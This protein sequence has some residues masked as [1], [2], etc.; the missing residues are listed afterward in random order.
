MHRLKTN[1]LQ[2]LVHVG[3][4]LPLAVLV[5]EFT[6]DGLTV[7][8]IQEIQLRT[9]KYALIL[10]VLS[11]TCTPISTYFG[12]KQVLWL[13][14]LLGLYSFMYA[15][16]HFLNFVW[17]DYG[18]DFNL[19]R[20]DIS[21]KRF[22]LVGFISFLSL[23][24]LTVTSTKGWKQRLGKKWESLHLLI[25][26]AT[27]LAVT[28]F[29]LQVKADFREPLIYGVVVVLLLTVRIPSVRRAISKF[30]S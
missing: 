7:N 25:Y 14:R 4:L 23:F 24:T 13:R 3:A 9:G 27:V 21:E 2:I 22:A 17:L 29:I 1:G 12:L 19:I 8:P 16:L 15:S 30:F 11:L 6:Q 26:L 5:W 28:H 20:E 18:F 10:L